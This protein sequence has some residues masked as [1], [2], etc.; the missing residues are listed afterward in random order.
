[1]A[2]GVQSLSVALMKRRLL[3]ALQKAAAEN[4]EID[5][6]PE[7]EAKYGG[8][9][10][11]GTGIDPLLSIPFHGMQDPNAGLLSFNPTKVGQEYTDAF[12]EFG[13]YNKY[14]DTEKDPLKLKQG[15]LGSYR[16]YYNEIRVRSPGFE[17]DY[18]LADADATLLHELYHPALDYFRL[19]PDLIPNV[20]F[21]SRGPN[22]PLDPR[23]ESLLP[24]FVNNVFD[25]GLLSSVVGEHK[26]IGA[27]SP[28]WL[29]RAHYS[30]QANLD[31]RRATTADER[32]ARR[33]MMKSLG[34]KTT[35]LRKGFEKKSKKKKKKKYTRPR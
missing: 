30:G 24:G 12:R 18:T 31:P 10:R 13:G 16:P 19:N 28:D 6:F 34:E 27:M 22:T 17:P 1:M 20:S 9:Y 11:G 5:Y 25:E 32:W 33:Q 15:T 23:K 29:E 3:A 2:K 21:V 4:E 14:L 8:P 7:W 26:L 35:E